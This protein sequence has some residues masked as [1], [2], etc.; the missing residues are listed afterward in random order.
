MA[1]VALSLA[2][3]LLAGGEASAQASSAARKAAKEVMEFLRTKFAR[4]VAE[5]GAEKVESR[6]AVAITKHGDGVAAAARRVGPR[7]ALSAAERWGADGAKLLATFGDDGA[8]LL[9][10]NGPGAMTVMKNL[11]DE[12]IDLMIR[13]NTGITARRLPD[14]AEA[15]QASGR[16]RDVL[17]VLEK[18]GDRACNF[19]WRNKGTIFAAA[20]LTAFLANPAPYLDGVVKLVEAPA[21]HI[22][23]STSWTSVIVVA[24]ILIAALAA[25]RMFLLRRSRAVAN[26][27][28]AD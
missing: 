27:S 16:S 24:T 25:F 17:A 23:G 10:V 9:A 20:A 13:T 28:S 22:A 15:I 12:G 5:E 21:R 26:P 2:I 18:Y 11:G 7:V 14:I 8:R 3:V 4:E 19:I 1:R 6:L